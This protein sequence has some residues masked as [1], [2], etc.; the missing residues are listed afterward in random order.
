MSNAVQF[1]IK[2]SDKFYK[3]LGLKNGAGFED[4]CDKA[5]DHSLSDAENIIKREVPRPG[6]S[7]SRANPPYKPT[8]NLQRSIHKTKKKKCSGELRS[9][10]RS[11]GVL[12]WPFVQYG[13]S[14]MPANPF[15]TRTV[16]KVAPKVKKYL[17][18]ELDAMGI[19][20]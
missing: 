7:M 8:G 4:A 20:D 2:F 14:K 12:Y 9:N 15:V 11:N 5:V 13:T 3:K 10:A 18:D 1:D 6:H 17:H 19:F 16:N